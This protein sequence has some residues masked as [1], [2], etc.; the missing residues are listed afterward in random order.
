MD[1]EFG[2]FEGCGGGDH[3]QNIG[4]SLLETHGFV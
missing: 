2:R 3:S 1:F 4:T